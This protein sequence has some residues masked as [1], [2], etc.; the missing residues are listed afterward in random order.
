MS[1]TSNI[2]SHL[3]VCPETGLFI[4]SYVTDWY[5]DWQPELPEGWVEFDDR[6]SDEPRDEYLKRYE[7]IRVRRIGPRDKVLAVSVSMVEGV[8]F[9]PACA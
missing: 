4:Q 6:L 7:S 8:A 1:N 5:T 3:P 9:I 2:P